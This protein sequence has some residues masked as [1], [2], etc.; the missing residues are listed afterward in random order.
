MRTTTTIILTLLAVIQ[1]HAQII[2]NKT[3]SVVI[4]K[5]L[6]QDPEIREHLLAPSEQVILKTKSG[7]AIIEIKNPP[8][9]TIKLIDVLKANNLL[10][11]VSADKKD[12]SASC[13]PGSNCD[14][15]DKND[16]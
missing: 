4:N 12:T 3:I 1:A 13:E 11:D 8:Q 16:P 10:K 7:N 6:M 5:K 2:A 9:K 15:D 14:G